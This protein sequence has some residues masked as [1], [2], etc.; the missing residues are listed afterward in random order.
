MK[1]VENRESAPQHGFDLIDLDPVPPRHVETTVGD[2]V[3]NN[4]QHDAG[5]NDEL[6]RD[7]TDG[8]HPELPITNMPSFVPPRRSTRDRHPST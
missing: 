4:E 5:D 7:V 3:Q 2:D 6:I 1:D 8:A